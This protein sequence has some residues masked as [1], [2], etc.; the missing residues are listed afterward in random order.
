VNHCAALLIP[1]FAEYATAAMEFLIAFVIWWELEE[2]RRNTFLSEASGKEVY[3]GRGRVY[4]AFFN[5]EGSSIEEKGE[6]LSQ[7]IWKEE[8]FKSDCERQIVFFNRLGQ[9]RRYALFHKRDYVKLFP[10]TV[11]LFWIMLEPYIESRRALTGEWWASDFMEL[12][13]ECLRFVLEGAD[14]KLYVYD[15]DRDRKKDLVVSASDLRRVQ[16]RIAAARAES[17]HQLG[18]LRRVGWRLM[19]WALVAFLSFALGFAAAI[20]LCK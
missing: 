3:E 5:I 18:A 16:E 17:S 12:T 14:P 6:R 9:I 19:P 1:N 8:A 20:E 15:S 10:H 11:V 2:N 7:R 4:S 13:G